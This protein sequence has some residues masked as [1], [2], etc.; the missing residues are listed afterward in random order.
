MKLKPTI[1]SSIPFSTLLDNLIEHLLEKNYCSVSI[2]RYLK[3]G[4]KISQYLADMGKS[5]IDSEVYDSLVF[6][7]T[8][9]SDCQEKPRLQKELLRCLNATLEF[10]AQRE[11]TFRDFQ[12]K[13]SFH[14]DFGIS[15]KSYL[16]FCKSKG[17]ADRTI[18]N[19]REYL[20][21]FQEHLEVRKISNPTEIKAE[22]IIE[23]CLNLKH[24]S[25]PTA[26]CM[27]SALREYLKYLFQAGV[28]SSDLSSMVPKDNYKK[29][30]KLPSTY[31]A[32]E[33]RKML[34]NVDRAN[35]KGKRDYA[36]I[37]LAALLGI[38][39][40]DVCGLKFGNLNWAQNLIIFEQKKTHTPVELPLLA[41]I[42]N[43]LIDYLRYGRPESESPYIFLHAS[44]RYEKLDKETFHSIVTHYLRVSGIDIANR[45]HGPHALRHSLASRLLDAKIPL[46][47]I[48][49]T[50]G[51]RTSDSTML[52]LRID[53]KH[54]K[55]CALA[56]PTIAT[57][58]YGGA[59]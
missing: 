32:A 50:L 28:Q 56:V 38:R 47:V 2:K 23:Y 30:A 12:L 57:G 18:E 17:M 53:L 1:T 37:L 25:L 29:Q 49:E 40:S 22:T 26:H 36:M 20:I 42:G 54:L 45:K 8:N 24:Y 55:Q 34:S 48:S 39:A 46:P 11:I 16:E 27:L 58:V 21:R 52:Y 43:A 15:I 6:R 19:K 31:T 4:E 51:H 41:E 5:Y 33:I 44:G 13:V 14:G 59:R 7:I 3:C 9:E 10:A 35:P